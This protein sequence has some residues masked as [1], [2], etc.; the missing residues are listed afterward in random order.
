M[1]FVHPIYK[2]LCLLT[3]NSHFTPPHAP[4]SRV[5][6]LCMTYYHWLS[7]SS[8][9]SSP[10][11]GIINDDE[12]QDDDQRQILTGY[13]AQHCW[14]SM[15]SQPTRRANSSPCIWN[16]GGTYRGPLNNVCL[17]CVSPHA[18]FSIDAQS[19]SMPAG[20]T[21][22]IQNPRIQRTDQGSEH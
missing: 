18:F 3:P 1:F 22:W 4:G 2:S 7:S 17:N 12:G 15:I 13:Y 16:S 6:F 19:A 20:P 14:P 8:L 21:L 11:S 10:E 9:A 5:C